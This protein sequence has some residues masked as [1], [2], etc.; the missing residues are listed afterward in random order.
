MNTALQINGK[1]IQVNDAALAAINAA[2][3]DCP[4]MD[5]KHLNGEW[6]HVPTEKRMQIKAVFAL[7]N[8]VKA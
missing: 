2:I 1:S 5:E 8:E 3:K 6:T 7:S 4:V